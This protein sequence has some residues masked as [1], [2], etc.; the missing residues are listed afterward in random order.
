MDVLLKSAKLYSPGTSYHQKVRDVLIINGKIKQI[1][2]EISNDDGVKEIDIKGC[3]LMPGWVD[4]KVNFR[5]PGEEHKED[6]QSGLR[7]AAAG[8]FTEVLIMPS[9][10]YPIQNKNDVEFILH[11]CRNSIV[12]AHVAG[13][14]T[15]DRTGSEMTELYDMFQSGA[16]AFTDDKKTTSPGL[17][18]RALQYSHTFGGRIIVFADEAELN[19]HHLINESLSSVRTGM[20]G[21][22]ALAEELGL[23]RIIKIAEYCNIPVHVS[24]ISTAGSVQQLRNARNKGIK[25]T[26]EVYASHLLLDETLVETFNSNY[27]V[28]PVLRSRNDINALKK[29]ITEGVIDVVCSDHSPQDIEAKNCEYEFAAHGIASIETAFASYSTAFKGQLNADVIYNTLC[30]HPRSIL[31]L[32][33]PKIAEGENANLTAFNPDLTWKFEAPNML[34]K[35]RNTPFDQSHFTGKAIG[36]INNNKIFGFQEL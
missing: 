30:Y 25:I 16:V 13:C 24:G 17:L 9:T 23:N 18:I 15:V 4:M 12:S 3:Y 22:P 2:A 35:S 20:K 5:E 27:K 6:L 31:N 36:I 28:K 8:G 34:S 10:S 7:A 29:G 11:K 19:H 1:A 26:S 14:L 33:I 21:C 32:T